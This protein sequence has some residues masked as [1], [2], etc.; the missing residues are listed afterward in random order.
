MSVSSASSASRVDA[1][2]AKELSSSADLTSQLGTVIVQGAVAVI[3][4]GGEIQTSL[5]ALHDCPLKLS[6]EL[7][8]LFCRKSHSR[9]LLSVGYDFHH[10]KEAVRFGHV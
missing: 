3:P 10:T 8:L 4:F 9:I 2:G 1:G 5:V 7:E 6:L